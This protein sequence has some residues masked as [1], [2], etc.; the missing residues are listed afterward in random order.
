MIRY[1]FRRLLMMI[2]VVLGVSFIIF[3]FMDMAPGDIIGVIGTDYSQEAIDQI[4]EDLGLNRSVFYRYWKFI[5]GFVVGDMGYSYAFSKP[6]WELYKQRFPYT[7]KLALASVLVMVVLSLPLG[8]M[9]ALKNGS[10]ADNICNVFALLGLSI[11]NF[12]LG[13]LLII[14]FAQILGWF[15]SYGA[16]E[17]FKS[18]VL[19]AVTIGTSG[20]AIMTRTTRSAMLDVLRAD[21]LRTAR[22][23]GVDEFAVVSHHGFRNALIPIITIFG[24]QL[25]SCFGGAVVTENVFSYPGIGQVLVAGINRRDTTLVC[26]CIIMSVTIISLVQLLVDIMYAFVDPRLR[27]QYSSAKKNKRGGKDE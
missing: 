15:P 23:K 27:S 11:P 14:L 18:I 3:F 21:Y 9:A 13:L 10:V 12:W 22:S 24:T 4:E 6:V 19:P 7:A 1:I 25:A 20:M 2:P 17:G 5:K 16:E 8:I 26:G